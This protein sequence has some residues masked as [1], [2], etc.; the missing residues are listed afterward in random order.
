MGRTLTRLLGLD[1]GFGHSLETTVTRYVSE[2]S[3][4]KNLRRQP[5]SRF[6]LLWPNP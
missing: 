6:G 1:H 3:Q 5:R 4:P 2:D